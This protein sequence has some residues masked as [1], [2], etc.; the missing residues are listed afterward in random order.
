MALSIN[1][2]AAALSAYRDLSAAAAQLNQ[3]SAGS[4]RDQGGTAAAASSRDTVEFSHANA[5][6]AAS[7]NA[8]SD[9]ELAAQLT[10][11]AAAQIGSNALTALTAQ[12]NSSPDAVLALLQ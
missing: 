11:V 12:A 2:S 4:A 5:A 6:A 9:P 1:T 3:T 8:I 10:L 7:A